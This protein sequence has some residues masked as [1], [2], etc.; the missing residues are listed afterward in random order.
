M[1]KKVA[2][3]AC[4]ARGSLL[5]VAHFVT[6]WLI[7]GCSTKFFFL[8][9]RRCSAPLQISSKIAKI[10]D[11]LGAATGHA[12]RRG[13]FFDI[14]ELSKVELTDSNHNFQPFWV[15]GWQL[16]RYIWAKILSHW[17]KIQ[18]WSTLFMNQFFIAVLAPYSKF[19]YFSLIRRYER[20]CE[21][22]LCEFI[23]FERKS[24]L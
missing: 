8:F 17:L 9:L 22:N 19:W 10:R 15:E 21:L 20:F 5:K 14:F 7:F 11:F 13:N 24:L 23:P 3:S 16:D 1:S 4:I 2:P 18:K 6:F 12:G